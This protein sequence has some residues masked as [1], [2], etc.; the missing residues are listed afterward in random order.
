M[1]EAIQWGKT[2]MKKHPQYE[3]P[4]MKKQLSN[5]HPTTHLLHI[6]LSYLEMIKP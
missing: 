1:L 5:S 3:N 4:N 2:T 6:G